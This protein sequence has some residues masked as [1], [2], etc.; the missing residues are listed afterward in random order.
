MIHLF[1]LEVTEVS[2]VVL[3]Q[4]V[5]LDLYR[6][7]MDIESVGK[8]VKKEINEKNR[9]KSRR[10][11]LI[12]VF[13]NLCHSTLVSTKQ[14]KRNDATRLM[15]IFFDSERTIHVIYFG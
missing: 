8:I 7:A 12:F 3:I 4:Q 9:P 2:I 5:I 10:Q 14:C 15:T 13:F 1:Q 11:H 6:M